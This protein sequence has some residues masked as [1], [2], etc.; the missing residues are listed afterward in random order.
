MIQ[1][2]FQGEPGAYSEVAVLQIFP[3][4]RPVPSATFREVFERVASGTVD[5]GVLPIENSLTGSIKENDDLLAEGGLTLV[6]ET[7]L[8]V[9]HC[10]MA[11]PGQ[12]LD[13]IQQVLSHP[14]ALEQCSDF[15]RR[16]DVEAV[17]SYDTAGS[18]KR[19]REE[20][21]W[22]AAAIASRRAA[23]IYQL[24]ILAENLQN[25]PDNFTRFLA[26]ARPDHTPPCDPALPRKTSLVLGLPNQPGALHKALGVLASRNLQL[27]RLESRPSLQKPWEY[28]FSIDFEGDRQEPRVQSAM[29]ELQTQA[30]FLVLLGTYPRAR[31]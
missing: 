7:D 10:L 16:L 4:A 28:R 17:P 27:T 29:A 26:I 2:A 5:W 24:A 30:T 11:L 20:G 13:Q 22:G 25:Q 1:V 19:I 3:A 6:G 31:A 15:L 8:P 18:A 12:R 23:E 21:R 14:Q 9:R